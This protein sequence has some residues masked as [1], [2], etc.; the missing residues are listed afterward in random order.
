KLDRAGFQYNWNFDS[1][2]NCTQA[3]LNRSEPRSFTT[4]ASGGGFTFSYNITSTRDGTIIGTVNM[5]GSYSETFLS[6]SG[7]T[8]FVQ[9]GSVGSATI[10]FREDI[11]LRR[12]AH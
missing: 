3:E 8:R 6:A 11:D 4:T 7:A 1:H 2:G 9:Q 5:Q 10:D 12:T